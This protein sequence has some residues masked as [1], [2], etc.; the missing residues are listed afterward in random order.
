MLSALA[1]EKEFITETFTYLLE[2]VSKP[3]KYIKD[4]VPYMKMPLL[5]STFFDKEIP[6]IDVSFI[7]LYFRFL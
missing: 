6:D 4:F 5:L 2:N 7:F 1:V 3:P